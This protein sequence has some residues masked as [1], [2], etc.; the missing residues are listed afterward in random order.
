MIVLQRLRVLSIW[1]AL[2]LWA[3]DN[4]PSVIES[5]LEH[6][7]TTTDILT[8]LLN[9]PYYLHKNYTKFPKL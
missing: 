5:V 3:P 4:T 6:Q 1:V 9:E 7:G 8:F 2:W